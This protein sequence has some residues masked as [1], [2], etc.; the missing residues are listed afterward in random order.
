MCE[1]YSTRL[2]EDRREKCYNVTLSLTWNYSR[3]HERDERNSSSE[4]KGSNILVNPHQ[5]CAVWGQIN[6][7]NKFQLTEKKSTTKSYWESSMA[8]AISSCNL[9]NPILVTFWIEFKIFTLG[10]KR[11]LN[12]FTILFAQQTNC[13]VQ[14]RFD[15][16]EQI[17]AHKIILGARSPVFAAMFQHQM[18]ETKTGKVVVKDIEPDIF[19]ELLHFV[20]SG[21]IRAPLVEDAAQSLFL[22]AEKYHIDDLQHECI[23]FLLSCIR[24]EN[25]T[26]LMAWAHVHSVEKVKEA[27]LAFVA[28]HG[29]EI[30]QL[31]D[32]GKLIN[33][34][35]ELALLATRQ[36]MEKMSVVG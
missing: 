4:G 20:Y 13:D 32:W 24:V 14:F 22:A 8:I 5:P 25:A 27:A 21:R 9:R 34:H 30:C 6:G 36:M 35:P 17:G 31:E 12:H 2:V 18:E 3:F 19:K 7:G 29:K 1:I 23:Q 16:G 26:S 33:N 10:E 15:G 28:L 11:T